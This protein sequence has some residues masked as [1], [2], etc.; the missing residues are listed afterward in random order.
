MVHILALC[1]LTLGF[2]AGQK[3]YPHPP[4]ALSLF[5]HGVVTHFY[6]QQHCFYAIWICINSSSSLTPLFVRLIAPLLNTR[7]LAL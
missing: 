1:W 5:E 6:P 7:L 2:S 3:V 4:I